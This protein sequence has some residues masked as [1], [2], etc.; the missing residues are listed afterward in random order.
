MSEHGKITSHY[1]TR[2]NIRYEIDLWHKGLR[3]SQTIRGTNQNDVWLRA[4]KKMEQWDRIAKYNDSK[5]LAAERTSQ[6]QEEFQKLKNLLSSSI[7]TNSAVDWQ[8]LKD[9]SD[10]GKA[11]PAMAVIPQMDFITKLIPPWREK[12]ERRVRVQQEKYKI[13]VSDW[14][15]ERNVYLQKRDEQNKLVDERKEKYLSGD[16]DAIIDYYETVLSKSNYPEYFPQ[17]FELEY[18]PDNGLFIVEYQLPSPEQIPTLIEVVYIQSRDTFK[19]KHISK[20][21]LNNLYDS[22]VYQIVLRIFHELFD[23][24]RIDVIHSIVIN[25]Y[26]RSTDPATG[27]E[28]EACILTLQVGKDEYK[29]INLANVDPKVCFK[30]LKGIGSSKLHS[31]TP[32]APILK[33]DKED[34]RFVASYGV[35]SELGEAVNIAAMDWEDFEHLVR[36]LFEKEFTSTGGEV[37]VTQASRDGGVDAVAFDPD[38][39]RGG[40][41]VIQAKRYSNTVG[42]S[43]VR[44]LYGTVLNEGATKGVLVAT[45]DYGPDAYEFAKGKP[46]VL[47]NGGNLLHLLQKHGHKARIDLKEAK[48]ILGGKS[49]KQ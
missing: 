13:A 7:E 14:E 46:L 22:I 19:E 47:L 15:N 20:T 45:S 48:K 4:Q 29:G 27:H 8:A 30:S 26:V 18:R 34:A 38:P 37:K 40:K 33:I 39:I 1:S 23:S 11:K 21:Q 49:R 44:D 3:L 10:F 31:L 36:E 32:V 35:A 24:D 17:E 9:F 2:G 25:G 5:Q 41:I 16:F 43:A 6:A 28:V 42:V 12:Y